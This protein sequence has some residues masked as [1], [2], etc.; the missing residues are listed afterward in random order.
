MC[1]FAV[2]SI[3]GGGSVMGVGS[4]KYTW[5]HYQC[6]ERNCRLWTFKLD[7]NGSTYTEGCSLQFIGLSKDEIIKNNDMKI[8]IV[9]RIARGDFCETCAY[10]KKHFLSDPTCEKLNKTVNKKSWCEHFK[11]VYR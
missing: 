1:P 5:T 11:R 8:G 10:A 6:L 4:E 7:E 9:E 3:G 2:A